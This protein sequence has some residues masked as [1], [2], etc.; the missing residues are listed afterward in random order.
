MFACQAQEM[1]LKTEKAD[2]FLFSK[3]PLDK[4]QQW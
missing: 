3:K 1:Y 2:V 4:K